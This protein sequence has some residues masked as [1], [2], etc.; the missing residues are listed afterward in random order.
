MSAFIASGRSVSP[1]YAILHGSKRPIADIVREVIF[2]ATRISI[3]IRTGEV[4][5]SQDVLESRITTK[6]VI[7]PILTDKTQ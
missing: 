5:S 1:I 3:A 2:V 7:R 4:H 6:Y